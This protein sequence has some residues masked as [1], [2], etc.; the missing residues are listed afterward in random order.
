MSIADGDV[1]HTCIRAFTEL[2]LQRYTL[3]QPSHSEALLSQHA[4]GMFR[5]ATE[6]LKAL[7]K[8]HDDPAFD[9]VLLPQAE[10]CM[11]SLGHAMAYSA[12]LD[13]G[14]PPPL[15]NIF[16]LWVIRLDEA[17]YVENG[18]LTQT[19]TTEMEDATLDAALPHL[20]QYV[21]MLDIR[22]YCNVPIRSDETWERWA[23]S[24]GI[25]KRPERRLAAGDEYAT[26]RL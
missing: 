26:A 7:P 4:A 2:I 25:H 12:A 17:W 10:A 14:V 20:R 8:G 24:L 22:K 3:P 23:K 11:T 13:A 18:G 19:V 6:A 15:L 9:R 16:E 1:L 21:D 5:R